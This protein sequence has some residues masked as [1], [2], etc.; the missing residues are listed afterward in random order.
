MKKVAKSRWLVTLLGAPIAL[1]VFSFA[2]P[3]AWNAL[4]H[5][6]VGPKYVNATV[7]VEN[8]QL[9]LFVRNNSDDPLDLVGADI[10]IK[11]QQAGEAAQEFGAYPVVSHLY[12][13]DSPSAAQ[14]KQQNGQLLV[15]LKITQAIEARQADQ[16]GFKITDR[17]GPFTP[18]IG[19]LVGKIVDTKGN[20]YPIKY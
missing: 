2:A 18:P 1:A 4:T 3:I 10:A 5:R 20:S 9:L 14:L 7:R 12:E 13:V 19:S 15:T 8:G 16:F 6:S 17:A 11:I